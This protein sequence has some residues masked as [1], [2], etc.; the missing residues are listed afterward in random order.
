MYLRNKSYWVSHQEI[1]SCGGII[2]VWG[3]S[4]TLDFVCSAIEVKISRND[5]LT[6]S[7][8][9]K[10]NI[11]ENIANTCYILCPVGLIQEYEVHEDW[12]LLWYNEEKDRIL[13]KKM[14][15][16][17]EMSD[18]KKLIALSNFLWSGRNKQKKI[19]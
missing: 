17:K 13:N 10:N 14:P 5:F 12:G 6:K 19:K 18:R 15:K 9:M 8:K 3:L 16:F 2:D 1:T 11:S 7:Q 4:L